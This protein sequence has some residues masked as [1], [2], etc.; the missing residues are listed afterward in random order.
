MFIARHLA[1]ITSILMAK[2]KKHSSKEVQRVST[3]IQWGS[4]QFYLP[5]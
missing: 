5:A 3:I 2:T 4:G 1:G